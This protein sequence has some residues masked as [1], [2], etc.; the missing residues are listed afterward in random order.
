[1]KKRRLCVGAF[2]LTTLMI[3]CTACSKSSSGTG[4]ESET[5]VGSESKIETKTDAVEATSKTKSKDTLYVAMNQKIDVIDGPNGNGLATQ[6]MLHV[7]D[8]LV[9][10]NAEGGIDPCLATSWKSTD[11]FTWQFKLQE[12]IKYT[13]GEDFNAEAV[14]VNIEY[15]AEYFRYSSQF[16][17]SWPITCKV[18]DNY[19]VDII[20]QTYCPDLPALLARVPLFAPQQYQQEGAEVFFTHTVGTGPYKV[21]A[22]D[23]GLSC[24]VVAN[25]DYWGGAPAI[26]KIVFDW[27]A[28][29]SS[30]VAGLRAGD[31]D[32]IYVV[33]FTQINDLR[34]EGFTVDTYGTVGTDMIFY[35]GNAEANAWIHNDQFRLAC[36]YAIDDQAI[37]DS[38][39]EGYPTI[40]AGIADITTL[41]AI[42]TWELQYDPDKAKEILAEIGYD[43]DPLGF[44]YYTGE[45][46]GQDEICEAVASYLEAVGIAVD[47]QVIEQAAFDD[48]VKN[49]IIDV[50][51]QRMPGPYYGVSSYYIRQ[52]GSAGRACT[53][54]DATELMNAANTYGLSEEE[55]I[56][57]LEAANSAFWAHYPVLWGVH[58]VASNG[59]TG[60]LKGVIN[61]P[62]SFCLFYDSYFE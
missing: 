47:L 52:M 49:G 6:V 37:V 51:A 59:L 44:H 3:V 29:E 17:T 11:E 50:A 30:R 23:P 45:F 27:V 32:F 57:K 10:S 13:N 35:D 62:N 48:T 20:S 15:L 14:K 26:K 4:N 56:K 12:G 58:E 24:T 33:P 39:L 41:G 53:F 31:Y 18:V 54:D 8:P 2:A 9:R 60:D 1:M 42:D 16:G 28:D 43:G 40:L 7:G 55:R 36:I 34:T 61:L 46:S 21:E 5:K 22:F 19:T 38:L 25:E